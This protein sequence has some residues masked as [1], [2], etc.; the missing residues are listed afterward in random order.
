MKRALALLSVSIILLI[1]VGVTFAQDTREVNKS[2]AFSRDGRF[3]LDTYK[4]SIK[5]VP[6]D[7]SEIEIHAVIEADGNSRY[8]RDMVED[9]EIRIDLSSNTARVKTDYDH[10]KHRHH[11]F[12]GLF[13]YDSDNLPFVHYTIKLPNT[14]HV[15]IKDYKSQTTVDGL[16]ADLELE[17]YK[18]EVS[19]ERLS[20]GI[21]LKTYKGE[22]HVNFTSLTSRSRVETYKGEIELSLPR[23]KGYD[24]DASIGRHARLQSDVEWARDSK[25]SRKHGYETH[26]SVNGGGPELR[27]KS[28]HGTIR[29]YER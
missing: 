7:K 29:V 8:D 22:G 24:L 14:A 21:D 4:G 11:G 25:S 3:S 9:T 10:A 1:A 18:G 2:G 26:S 15:V 28:D 17:T 5:I 27:L 6:W 12:L 19:V 23:G 16:Q 20:G 13:T